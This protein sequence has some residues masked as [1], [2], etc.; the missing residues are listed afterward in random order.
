MDRRLKLYAQKW[1]WYERNSLPWNRLAIHREFLRREAF[2][3]WPVHGNVLEALREG[4]LV[5]GAGT[6]LE[7]NVWITAPGEA[8]IR[9]GSGWV[10]RAFETGTANNWQLQVYAVCANRQ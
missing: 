10:G 6:L 4:R 2:V 3:R 9:I 7:P 5:I 1:R 8:R